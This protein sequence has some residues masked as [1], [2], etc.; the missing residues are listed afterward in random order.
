M[1]KDAT[2][3]Q[4]YVRATDPTSGDQVAFACIDMA[5]ANAKAAELRMSRHQDV[6]MSVARPS[7]PEIT[8]D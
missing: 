5:T 1:R 4:Y 8:T 3:T 6:I 7:E 2:T